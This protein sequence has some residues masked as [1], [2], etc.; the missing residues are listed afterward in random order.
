MTAEKQCASGQTHSSLFHRICNVEDAVAVLGNVTRYHAHQLQAR[1]KAAAE[2]CKNPKMN[3][4][5]F[6]DLRR[7]TEFLVSPRRNHDRSQSANI[8]LHMMFDLI[9]GPVYHS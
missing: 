2:F 9:I 1:R 4:G 8:V 3:S 7:S 5:E 6:G